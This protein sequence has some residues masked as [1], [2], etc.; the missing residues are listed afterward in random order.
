MAA[1]MREPTEEPHIIRG[2]KS[3][4]YKANR[5]PKWNFPKVAPPD[6][7]RAVLPYECLVS[8][9]NSNF[10]SIDMFVGSE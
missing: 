9:K 4:S 6:R 8:A 3:Y 2:I 1:K 10:D 7:N 5:S